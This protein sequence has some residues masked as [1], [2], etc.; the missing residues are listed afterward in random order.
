[1]S[2]RDPN[3]V[4]PKKKNGA[5][6]VAFFHVIETCFRLP[7]SQRLFA[8]RL[9]ALSA[10]NEEESLANISSI[11]LGTFGLSETARRTISS[12]SWASLVK[13]S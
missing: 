5:C 1:M 3:V 4:N 6:Y 8:S 12:L 7:S 11:S 10:I 9:S 13:R 2:L